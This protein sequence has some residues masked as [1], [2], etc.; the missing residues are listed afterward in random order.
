LENG[1]IVPFLDKTRVNGS[2]L[3]FLKKFP[4]KKDAIQGENP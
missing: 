3:P 2:I 4:D 1:S